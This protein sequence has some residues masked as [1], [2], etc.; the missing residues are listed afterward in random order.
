[1]LE[2][3][4]SLRELTTKLVK[5][6]AAVTDLYLFGSRRWRTG[7]RRSDLDILVCHSRHI[8]PDDFRSFCL[9][10]CPALDLFLV[11]GAKAVSVANE[12]YVEAG[13]FEELIK[14]L[15]AIPF[16]SGDKGFLEADVEWDF[17]VAWGIDFQFTALISGTPESFNWSKELSRLFEFVKGQGLP[18]RPFIGMTAD[19]A[20]DFLIE[21]LRRLL[22]ELQQLDT[23]GKGVEV[24]FRTEYDLQN[25][26][27]LGVKP[28]LPGLARREVTI[29]Y[30]GQDK[31]ADFN[32]FGS[33]VVI[34][35]KHIRDPNTKAAVAKT[36]SGLR[37]FYARHPNVRVLLFFI[38]VNADVEL[39]DSRWEA[40]YSYPLNT[41]AVKTI[42]L[43][44][45]T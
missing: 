2:T 27:F 39:D 41:P 24:R 18:H 1:M 38:L 19:E 26:F 13:T 30:D 4:F 40:D 33:Q 11:D 36:L 34:E 12:S 37:D 25:V 8:R 6:F 35:M 45:P 9:T 20:A 15:A 14:Q 16:W 31:S 22:L 10:N 3:V 44:Y 43:R 5:R 32:V 28:W 17:T 42:I 23:K 7:S 21:I 29:R